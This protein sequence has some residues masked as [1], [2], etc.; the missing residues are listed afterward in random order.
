MQRRLFFALA[1][2]AIVAAPVAADDKIDIKAVI[3]KAIK[4][5]GGKETLEKFKVSRIKGKGTLHA[6]GAD[7]EFSVVGVSEL[8]NKLRSEIKLDIMGQSIEIVRVFDGKNG[9]QSAMGTTMELTDEQLDE[10]KEEGHH[11]YIEAIYTLAADKDLQITAVGEEKVDGKPAIGLKVAKKGHKD[12]RVYFDK[13]SGLLVKMAYKSKDP[14]GQEV[15]AQAFYR[16]YKDV[17]GTKVSMKQEVK[18]G[19]EKFI[20]ATLSDVKLEEKADPSTFAKP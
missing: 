10:M 18:H 11:N 12:V 4:A 2:A 8:P 3:D 9:W 7:I 20:E 16:D 13:D 1:V 14:A 5:H 15:D 17:Q 19:D 6:M